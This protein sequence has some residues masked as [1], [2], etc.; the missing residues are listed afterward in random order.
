MLKNQESK[1]REGSYK[2][3]L[4]PIYHQISLSSFQPV[5]HCGILDL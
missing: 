4:D 2:T 1:H 5:D 3:E